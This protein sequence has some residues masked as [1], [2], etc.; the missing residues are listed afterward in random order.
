[1]HVDFNTRNTSLLYILIG[2]VSFGIAY[3]FIRFHHDTKDT[4]A[5]VTPPIQYNVG[6]GQTTDL[7]PPAPP[8]VNPGTSTATT[9]R[10]VAQV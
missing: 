1:M 4:T 6:A 8:I 10:P 7:P 9:S 2:L 5:K 3:F